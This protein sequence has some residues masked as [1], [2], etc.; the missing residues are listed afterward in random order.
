MKKNL[1]PKKFANPAWKKTGNPC[2]LDFG[3]KCLDRYYS[4]IRSG[5]TRVVHKIKKLTRDMKKKLRPKKF[6]NPT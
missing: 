3:P 2:L 4:Y 5:F 1:R 6:G